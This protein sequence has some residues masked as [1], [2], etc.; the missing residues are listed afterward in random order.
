M[1]LSSG[2]F[3]FGF[4][5]GDDCRS[6][7]TDA[8][9]NQRQ[10]SSLQVWLTRPRVVQSFRREVDKPFLNPLWMSIDVCRHDLDGLVITYV[11]RRAGG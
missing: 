3:F 7:S 9:P 5:G 11:G 8:A 4:R 10:R 2:G 6:A 1:D